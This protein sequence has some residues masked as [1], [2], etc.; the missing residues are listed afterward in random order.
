[1]QLQRMQ[2]QVVA[3]FA[4]DFTTL[5]KLHLPIEKGSLLFLIGQFPHR[6]SFYGTGPAGSVSPGPIF[7]HS[8]AVAQPSGDPSRGARATPVLDRLRAFVRALPR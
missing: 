7:T 8:A 6:D 4:A 2:L 3:E 1:M 5:F